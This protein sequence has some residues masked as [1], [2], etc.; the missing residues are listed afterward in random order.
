MLNIAP[1]R[2]AR[3]TRP[4]WFFD[5]ENYGDILTDIGSHQV[6]QF[7]AYADYQDAAINFS[8]VE[9]FSHPDKPGFPFFGQL[10]LDCLNRTE[11]AMTQSHAFKAAELS[12]RAQQLAEQGKG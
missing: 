9:S 11:H 8:R 3:E 4:D 7:L 5:K 2:L 10:I 6:E 1:R 12:M